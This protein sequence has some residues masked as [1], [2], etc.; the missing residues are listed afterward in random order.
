MQRVGRLFFL[1]PVSFC[2]F[3]LGIS[4]LPPLCFHRQRVPR[5]LSSLSRGKTGSLSA[6]N[7]PAR[8]MSRHPAVP[9]PLSETAKRMRDDVTAR[10]TASA[11][12]ET[13]A[14]FEN[15]VKGTKWL[16]NKMPETRSA[17]KSAVKECDCLPSDLVSVFLDLMF[18]EFC[19]VKLAGMLIFSDHLFPKVSKDDAI[20]E[21]LYPG[22]GGND[23]LE[24]VGIIVNDERAV[25]DWS[26]CDWLCMKCISPLCEMHPYDRAEA[27]RLVTGWSLDPSNRL[28]KRRAGHVSFVNHV[29]RG[30][31]ETVFGDGFLSR[32]VSA[33]D[34]ALN[35]S[36]RFAQTG[37]GWVLRYA[38]L[39]DRPTVVEVLERRGPTMTV[40]G[41]RYALEQ[42]KDASLKKRLMALPGKGASVVD[43]TARGGLRGGGGPGQ[44][45]EAGGE[46]KGGANKPS[47]KNSRKRR[48]D[49]L[50]GAKAGEAQGKT[51]NDAVVKKRKNS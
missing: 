49:P 23:I 6:E 12:A 35:S 33:C 21:A 13:K 14:W 7:P 26:T 24:K 5:S 37:A 51:K 3:V 28:W 48:E 20:R 25:N 27:G 1:R 30:E 2:C 36:E 29:R 4:S 15:Y 16:G 22:E 47:N 38:L 50:A 9:S 39:S 17:V 10:L 46:E 32:V 40:E 34:A 41:M 18:S 42:C 45:Q 44:S 43:E 8:S 19:D 11:S 31:T